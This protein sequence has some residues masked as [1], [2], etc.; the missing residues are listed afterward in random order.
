MKGLYNFLPK[1]NLSLL[2][3]HYFLMLLICPFIISYLGFFAG[4]GISDYYFSAAI[5][6]SSYMF[7]TQIKQFFPLRTSFKHLLFANILLLVAFILYSNILDMS[8]DGL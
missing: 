7:I 1:E 6:F 2:Y 5:L 8:Y 3:A 4:L